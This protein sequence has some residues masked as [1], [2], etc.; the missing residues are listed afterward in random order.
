MAEKKVTMQMVADRLG[1]SKSTVSKAISNNSGISKKTR[2]KVLKTMKEMDFYPSALARN[3]ARN[4][5][6][7]IGLILPSDD[8]FFLSPFFQKCLRGMSISS[9]KRGYDL[10]IIYNGNDKI[11]AV[12]KAIKE[13]K[14]DGVIL[15]RSTIN[16]MVVKYLRDNNFP[17]VLIGKSLD[18]DDINTVDTKNIKASYELCD[19]LIKKGYKKIAFIGGDPLSVVTIDREQGYKEALADN[20]IEFIPG[21]SIKHS[22]TRESG[23]LSIKKV[24][25]SFPDVDGIIVSDE[26]MFIGVLNYLD[27]YKEEDKKLA[28]GLFGN[29]IFELDDPMYKKKMDIVNLDI[30]SNEIGVKSIDKLINILEGKEKDI[31]IS[32]YVDYSI[33]EY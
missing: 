5:S 32:T 29:G 9:G 26:L 20:N 24:M 19:R 6:K 4:V 15:L 16:N 1:I 3:L 13:R 21:L 23:F 22:F 14:I 12:E 33:K 28:M 11:K 27:K 7:N 17:F 25:E 2:E 31:E 8:D 10:L 30:N 18:Y